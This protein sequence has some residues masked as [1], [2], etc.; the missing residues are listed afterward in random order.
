MQMFLFFFYF[1]IVFLVHVFLFITHTVATVQLYSSE[2]TVP[3][4]R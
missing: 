2:C 3:G 4:V 1:M